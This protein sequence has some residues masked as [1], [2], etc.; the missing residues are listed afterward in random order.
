MLILKKVLFLGDKAGVKEWRSG[1]DLDTDPFGLFFS[2]GYVSTS[3]LKE[4]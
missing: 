1:E 3:F 2:V 4:T